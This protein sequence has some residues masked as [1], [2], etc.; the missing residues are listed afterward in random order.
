[1]WEQFGERTEG[2]WESVT[3]TIDK[4]WEDLWAATEMAKASLVDMT[5]G[6]VNNVKRSLQEIKESAAK[7]TE[8][9]VSYRDVLA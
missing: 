1:M 3:T 7:I 9:A 8:T 4:A 2:L 6:L 5:V